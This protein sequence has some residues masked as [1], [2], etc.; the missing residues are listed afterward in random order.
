MNS[1]AWQEF[2]E[3]MPASAPRAVK[4]L[5]LRKRKQSHRGCGAAEIKNKKGKASQKKTKTGNSSSEVS[6]STTVIAGKGRD[7]FV[8]GLDGRK[9][10]SGHTWSGPLN[11]G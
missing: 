9:I 5:T 3:K 4:D 2:R 11:S 8:K 1:H 7:R 10:R 6:R